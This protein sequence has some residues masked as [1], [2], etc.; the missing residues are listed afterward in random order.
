MGAGFCWLVS[1]F[2]SFGSPPPL[3]AGKAG[4]GVEFERK[5]ERERGREGERETETEN[6]DRQTDR[7]TETDRDRLGQRDGQTETLIRFRA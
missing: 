4:E 1:F 2:L 3:K 5:R 7:Q 6:R